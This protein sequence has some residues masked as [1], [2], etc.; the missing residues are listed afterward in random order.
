MRLISTKCG[1]FGTTQNNPRTSLEWPSTNPA[2][3]RTFNLQQQPLLQCSQTHEETAC[4]AVCSSTAIRISA[5]PSAQA[6]AAFADM[7][8]VKLR[9][10]QFW[11]PVGSQTGSVTC[12]VHAL[13]V[14]KLVSLPPPCRGLRF[15][16]LTQAQES[17]AACVAPHSCHSN[18]RPTRLVQ[19][20]CNMLRL[21]PR[22]PPSH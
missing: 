16:P 15:E 4:N 12:T 11:P 14:H 2:T 5:N 6:V 17:I 19:A 3:N 13:G 21:M 9:Q 8:S 18:A 1:P 20:S 10:E 22:E 7:R